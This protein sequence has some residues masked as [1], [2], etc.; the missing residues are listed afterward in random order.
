MR[1]LAEELTAEAALLSSPTSEVQRK[2]VHFRGANVARSRDAE[3]RARRNRPEAESRPDRKDR[4]MTEMLI[5][6]SLLVLASPAGS[7]GWG[8]PGPHGP[9]SGTGPCAG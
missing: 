2:S 4:P 5:A 7:Y 8:W 6:G 1:G 9:N 3:G